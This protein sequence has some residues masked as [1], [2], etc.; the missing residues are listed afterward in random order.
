M[1][2]VNDYVDKY[3][4]ARQIAFD[5]YTALQKSNECSSDA[6]AALRKYE[7]FTQRKYKEFT[8]GDGHEQ[9]YNNQ[10]L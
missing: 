2:A 8:Q 7:E 5:L 10:H 3:W 9:R 4:E 6:E 1:G